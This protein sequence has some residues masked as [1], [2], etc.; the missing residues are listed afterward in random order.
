[1]PV[2]HSTIVRPADPTLRSALHLA[3]LFA[4]IKLALHI[5]ANLWEAHIGYGYFRDELY[6]IICGR[7]LAWGYVDHGPGVAIQAN[8]A[9]ALFG[10]SLAGIRMLSAAGGAARVFLTGILAWSLGGRRP[11]QALA[12]LCVL[13]APQ[14]LGTDSYL[15]MNSIESIFWM[16]CLLALIFI[17]RGGS[18]KLWLLFGL[19]AGLGLLNKP[20]MTFFLVALLAALLLTSQRRLL[21]SKWAAAGVALL[22]LI[23]LPNLLWQINNH[24]PTLEFLRNG[25]RGNKTITLSPVAFTI[26]QI[27]NM[28]PLTILIWGAGLVHLLRRP[29]RRWLG[30]TFVFFFAIMM[31]MHA[32][33][34]YLAP[35]YP[36]VYAAGGIAWELRYARRSS[37]IKDRAYAFPI[38]ETV[39]VVGAIFILPLSIPLMPPAQW[40]NYTRA[41]HLDRIHSN[42]EMD[43]SGPLPQFY[44]DRFGWQEEVDQ[45]TRIYNALPPDRQRITGILCGNYGEASAI[46]FLGNNLPVALS[47]H[48]SYYLW[49][50]QGYT[51]DSMI[52]IEGSTAKHL[53][54]YFDS[55]QI[56]GRIGTPYSMPFEHKNIYLVSGRKFEVATVWAESKN[57]F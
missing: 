34:Y 43:S 21:A 33:D 47:R 45:V 30:L 31:A 14:Y 23:A 5:A 29:D 56:V 57:Y 4:A 17:L 3:F 6:Y 19:S 48:N 39:L 26:K 15:S 16:T 10:K 27:L 52:L 55:V 32:K 7:H 37:V 8:L 44:A 2:T 35:I 50:P 20:S 49:G 18:E 11:S 28:G 40:L 13:L 24:W 41:T 1:M 54:E 51:F 42:T 36:I 9:L 46:N 12:M 38:I 53:Q 22:I 25:Q